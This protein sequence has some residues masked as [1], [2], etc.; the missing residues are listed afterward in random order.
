V[1]RK[2]KK[3][4]GPIWG[5]VAV[6]A[7]GIAVFLAMRS[8]KDG[9]AVALPGPVSVSAGT[10]PTPDGG[11]ESLASFDLSGHEVTIREYREFL[12]TLKRLPENLQD[13][14]DVEGQPKTK[15]GHAPLD[16]DAMLAAA[17]SGGIWE[18]L[19]MS[20]ECPVANVD[21]W[22]ASAFCKWKNGRLPTQEEWFAALR[23]RMEN[24]DTMTP[25]G[26]GKISDIPA[27]D[28]TPAGLYGMAGS[29]AEW[30]QDAATNPANPLGEKSHVIV[31]G[32]YRR[33]RGGALAREWTTDLLQRRPD[34]GFRIVVQ[35]R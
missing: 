4:A 8:G 20:L 1:T 34:L 16:W 12:D 32:S 26:W 23:T 13:N 15:T 5:V 10:H 24:P 35:E 31:G 33:P 14:Y 7:A 17:R 28:Q 25:A 3:T 6:A 27:G 11:E 29:V 2:S 22:D 19:S 18:N 21:W 30:T 9:P